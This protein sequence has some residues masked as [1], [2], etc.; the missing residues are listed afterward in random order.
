MISET[1]V[2]Y[3]P[4]TKITVR[5]FKSP[6]LLSKDL[7]FYL[8][9]RLNA[10]VKSQNYVSLRQLPAIQTIYFLSKAKYLKMGQQDYLNTACLLWQ[11]FKRSRCN[12]GSFFLG[13]AP[14][15]SILSII[16]II[17]M[18]TVKMLFN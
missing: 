1:K 17:T 10:G 14:L 11:A 9:S 7:Y 4:I 15:I 13:F 3:Q 12:T 5:K 18:F 8:W 16:S 2:T 6:H